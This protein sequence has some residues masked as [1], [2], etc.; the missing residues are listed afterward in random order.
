MATINS[1]KAYFKG[2]SDTSTT[3][4][5]NGGVYERVYGIT[6][7]N[8]GATQLVITLSYISRQGGTLAATVNDTQACFT[9]SISNVGT[10]EVLNATAKT[11][12][13]TIAGQWMPGQT[14]YVHIYPWREGSSGNVY[15][16][17]AT[18]STSVVTVAESGMY[19]GFVR[20]F[21]SNS[22]SSKTAMPYVY[23]ED[24]KPHLAMPYVCPSDG[25]AFKLSV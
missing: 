4:G 19:G 13:F 5:Y 25:A 6:I 1:I 8:T 16:L 20:V 15:Y 12:T 9:T 17:N 22:A 21:D 23:T 7:G 14:V 10:K 18:Y 11:V 24:G 2:N 3:V